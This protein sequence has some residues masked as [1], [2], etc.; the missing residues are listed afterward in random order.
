MTAFRQ[1]RETR[2]SA[3][4]VVYRR[5]IVNDDML[6]DKACAWAPAFLL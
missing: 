1:A 4:Q 2:A 5:S 6:L 3:V